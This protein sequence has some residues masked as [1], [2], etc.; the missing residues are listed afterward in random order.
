MSLPVY[1]NTIVNDRGDVMPEAL[2]RV[3]TDPGQGNV[4]LYKDRDANIVL[5]NVGDVY[6][7]INGFVRFYL[8]P[9]VYR[10]HVVA[11]GYDRIYRHV[12]VEPLREYNVVAA[13]QYELA[14][15]DAG[16][17]IQFI[18]DNPVNVEIPTDE[19]VEFPMW[20]EITLIQAGDG[21][22]TLSG[23]VTIQ[24]PSGGPVRSMGKG[25]SI[26]LTLIGGDVWLAR[27]AFDRI[28]E[29]D[30][31]QTGDLKITGTITHEGDSTQTG[32]SNQT[33]DAQITG[34]LDVGNLRLDGNT[35]SSTN[36][37][38]DVDI[39]PA[40]SGKVRLNKDT[41]VDGDLDVA[42]DTVLHGN[43]R[44]KGTA[45]IIDSTEVDIGDNIIRLN[46]NET[47]EPTLSAGFE[48]ERGLQDNVSFLWDEFNDRWTTGGQPLHISD[49]IATGSATIGGELVRQMA[50]LDK[51]TYAQQMEGSSDN[52][53]T[54]PLGVKRYVEQFGLGAATPPG[55]SSL[56]GVNNAV[57]NIASGDFG[58]DGPNNIIGNALVLSAS[59]ARSQAFWTCG[60]S[61]YAT[62][63]F[64]KSTDDNWETD[65]GVV[66]LWTDANLPTTPV[67]RNFL[68]AP[69]QE[70]ARQ[71][72]GAA[73]VGEG[74][75][76]VKLYQSV[77][78][79]V[80]DE[81]L[82]IGDV[83]RTLEHTTGYGYGG[84]NLYKIVAGG[85]GTHDNG[86]Y[87]D[88][89]NGLQAMG[90]FPA[91]ETPL[92]YGADPTGQVDSS[93]AFAAVRPRTV[94]V[95]SGFY[96]LNSDPA[97]NATWEIDS[98]TML[99]GNGKLQG[100]VVTQSGGSS[101]IDVATYLIE[102]KANFS[103]GTH[104]FVNSGLR[105]TTENGADNNTFEWSIL[106]LIENRAT[107]GNSVGV[108]GKGE[109]RAADAGPTWGICAEAR[110]ETGAINTRGL[111]GI[112]SGVF[113]DGLDPHNTRI[114]IDVVAGSGAQPNSGVI[115][116]GVRI[117]L[118]TE[119]PALKIEH[120]LLIR[121][122]ADNA[123]TIRTEGIF[124]VGISFAGASLFRGID[125]STAAGSF[126]GGVIH[127]GS[128]QRIS[129]LSE[130]N[131]ATSANPGD[132][133]LPPAPSGFWI[134][135]IDGNPYKI[136]FYAN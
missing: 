112:E 42:G 97:K 36:S 68:A 127:M 74:D 83:A 84:G 21:I 35:V 43:L 18:S 30:I 85:T 54:T 39:T 100:A 71:A 98:G 17:N 3:R 49:L 79:M 45:T 94:F 95:P 70:A 34:R 60:H 72:I 33:G 20:S 56:Q 87:I 5:T 38:G 66:E 48:I 86:S 81:E 78:E 22:I 61:S 130:G 123:I 40:G 136:P 133:T 101:A 104:G 117:G 10:M 119:N 31:E 89:D 47:G 92:H 11:E 25:S 90:L 55:K 125:F 12:Q 57:V 102:R 121:D 4:T 44:V 64:Y 24:N 52:V 32:N 75:G 91:G 6:A 118:S 53:G 26:H 111:I 106:G 93:A 28:I 27:V 62:R 29:G 132:K 41:A 73:A 23:D 19:D 105:V 115:H 110:D 1:Q 14:I 134:V 69:T 109:K 122:A 114:G 107:A 16:N 65:S 113:A 129:F 135:M 37:D 15:T 126:N 46:A 124:S 116:A 2:L 96:L 128:G 63:I 120:G 50:F 51:A 13:E 7:D 88:L 131:V 82:V 80:A 77:S 67:T 108:Y 76:G 59:S 99:L 103:G 8:P 58:A 9:G